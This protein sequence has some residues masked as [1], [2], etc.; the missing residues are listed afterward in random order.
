MFATQEMLALRKGDIGHE[1]ETYAEYTAHCISQGNLLKNLLAPGAKYKVETCPATPGWP[2]SYTPSTF[3]QGFSVADM[4]NELTIS[5]IIISLGFEK[6]DCK[7]KRTLTQVGM[8]SL[9]ELL[10]KL[11]TADTMGR[12]ELLAMGTISTNE[13]ALSASRV[14]HPQK[15]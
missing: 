3:D 11:H 15:D 1:K 13:N 10:E 6:E 9:A 4:V 12:Q 14:D 8:K 7:L 2:T 5:M